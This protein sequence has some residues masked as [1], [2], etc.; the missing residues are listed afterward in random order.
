MYTD[1]HCVSCLCVFSSNEPGIKG[2]Y[3]TPSLIAGICPKCR[4]ELNAREMN[5]IMLRMWREKFDEQQHL[6]LFHRIMAQP[7]NVR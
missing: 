4:E 7:K 3:K 6:E 5:N 2:V 1:R